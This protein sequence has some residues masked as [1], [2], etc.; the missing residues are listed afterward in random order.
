MFVFVFQDRSLVNIRNDEAINWRILGDVVQLAG[1]HQHPYRQFR[2]VRNDSLIRRSPIPGIPCTVRSGIEARRLFL[3]DVNIFTIL[4]ELM[5][6]SSLIE[7][8]SSVT[9]ACSQ[10]YHFGGLVRASRN[11]HNIF[12]FVIT[13][14]AVF[15]SL[16]QAVIAFVR[17]L[18]SLS[19]YVAN[20]PVKK[21]YYDFFKGL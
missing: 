17:Y 16:I 18:Y 5:R 15:S 9:T 10:S 8:G 3:R 12:S 20:Y 1:P 13:I 21:T 6:T 4:T 19:L 2:Q 7:S 14:F 11:T